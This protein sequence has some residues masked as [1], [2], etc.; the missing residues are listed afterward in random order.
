MTAPPA[1]KNR[2]GELN[3]WSRRAAIFGGASLLTACGASMPSNRR[4]QD[5]FQRA[6]AEAWLRGDYSGQVHIRRG[7]GEVVFDGS[8]GVADEAQQVSF[9]TQTGVDIGSNSKAF[10]AAAVLMLDQDGRATL[11]QALGDIFSDAPE[12][13][14]R[15]TLH[16]LLTHTG[17]LAD[18]YTVIP[19]QLDARTL[20]HQIFAQPMVSAPG[21]HY[22]YSDIGYALLAAV[23][24]QISQ[25]PYREFVKERL[26][27]AADLQNTGFLDDPRWALSGGHLPVARGYANNEELDS[28]Q[29]MPKVGWSPIGPGPILANAS[30]G[31]KWLAA[32]RRGQV[33]DARHTRLMF[34]R[35]IEIVPGRVW[36]GYGWNIV[37]TPDRGNVISHSGETGSHNYYSQYLVDHD[38]Y[39][40]TSSNRI[41]GVYVDANGDGVISDEEIVSE[42]IPASRLGAIFARGTHAYASATDAS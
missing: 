8:A 6:I 40:A 39:V 41:W 15:I 36:Y 30:D 22:S 32:L 5:R 35:H 11:T 24:E 19:A 10:V 9:T 42:Q 21:Q 2:R 25:R 38:V 28:P 34:S 33:L 29:N 1:K 27:A 37:Q 7:H 12:T 13:H 14:A 16:Q 20:R 31:A 17:G 4:E 3:V 26:F 23:V 18:E